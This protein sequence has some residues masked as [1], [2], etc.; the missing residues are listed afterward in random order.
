M[1]ARSPELS[2]IEPVWDQLKRQMPLCHSVHD[3]EVGVQDLWV[4]LPPDNIRRLFNTMPDHV[5][6]CIA[7]GGGRE[8]KAR[9]MKAGERKAEERKI[10]KLNPRR[11][12]RLLIITLSECA[13]NL[14]GKKNILFKWSGAENL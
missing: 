7:A 9:E 8:R 5:A 11:P 6:A 2:P 4:H 10:T 13:K 3:L 14:I 1:A 12:T